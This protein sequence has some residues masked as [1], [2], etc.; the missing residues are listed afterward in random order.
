MKGFRQEYGID[1][2][3]K[4]SR[5]VKFAILRFLLSVVATDDLDAIAPSD[6]EEE[7]HMEYL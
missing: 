5:V 4:F 2:D 3:E 6:L 1:F 7:I